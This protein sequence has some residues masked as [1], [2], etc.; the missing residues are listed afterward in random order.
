M[1]MLVLQILAIML[2]AYFLGAALACGLR[3]L[4]APRRRVAEATAPVVR[5]VE[6][7]PPVRPSQPATVS[8]FEKALGTETP[9]PAP[10]PV[11]APP[12][13]RATPVAPPAP[14]A[15][16]IAAAAAV[17][18]KVEH[19]HAPVEAPHPA[20]PA[21]LIVP[22]PPRITLTAPPTPAVTPVQTTS[23]TA[24]AAGVATAAAAAAAAALARNTPPAPP[25]PAPAATPTAT[26]VTVAPKPE[27]AAAPAAVTAPVVA[28]PSAAPAADDLTRIRGID[29]A[30]ATSLN[31]LGTTRYSQIAGWMRPDVT[32]VN[33][34]LGFKHRVEREN[35]IEQAQI[36]SNRGETLY[37][38]RL[39]GSSLAVVQPTPTHTQ[40]P[41]AEPPVARAALASAAAQGMGAAI[42]SAA[43]AATVGGLRT[44]SAPMPVQAPVPP[45]MATPARVAERA[46]F[47]TVPRPAAQVSAPSSQPVVGA[48]VAAIAS[49][50]A[51]APPVQPAIRPAPAMAPTRDS[52]QRIG[53]ING[54]IE[55]LLNVQGVTRYSQIAAWS[56]PEVERFDRLLGSPGRVR[57]EN[58][59]EQAQTFVRSEASAPPPQLP[60]QT[61]PMS[62]VA[63]ATAA[64]A[65][66][67]AASATARPARL[68]DA[69]QANQP[70]PVAAPV[71]SDA[72]Q[73]SDLAGLRSVRSEA[74]QPTSG[75]AARGASL[76]DL[77]RIRGV[78]VLIEK[79]LNA[80]GVTS[81][82]QVANW[83]QDDI[84][85]YSHQL[86]F[87]G[88][89]ERENWVEQARILASGGFTEFSRRVDRGEVE[90]SR[91]KS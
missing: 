6:P 44:Q 53:G 91:P 16:P 7:L 43:A 20:P 30:I 82:D 37:A 68:Q 52:L 50:A 69:I 71:A 40:A 90:T 63:A 34:T 26:V 3:Q 18:T 11:V 59:I 60:V 86:D 23:S 84:A 39:A 79:R 81:Y 66:A 75:T 13:P 4:M 77:K 1:T 35:W 62:A 83:T 51:A 74:F 10:Q 47:A 8:R 21:E 76:D 36:L 41:L 31:G 42:A 19:P 22:P 54:E 55:K 80:L 48:P 57:R 70:A 29:K 72:T 28:T 89:I 9:R 61:A 5:P 78:G 73:R 56:T 58:W 15:P 67:A 49:P 17:V 85:R 25:A 38:R 87:K 65:A 12:P 64:A 45:P 2:G 32:R 46:A 14:T 27:R 88:R 24:M 33:Q